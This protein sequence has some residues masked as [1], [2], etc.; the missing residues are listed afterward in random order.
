MSNRIRLRMA[1]DAGVTLIE[2]LIGF[3]IFAILTTL[4]FT[5]VMNGA[6]N[7]K[8]VRQTTDLN[9]EA[10]LVLNRMSRE[11]REASAI[12]AAQNPDASNP[13]GSQRVCGTSPSPCFDPRADVS[14]TFEVDFNRNGAIEPLAA[15]P[16]RITYRYDYANRRLL[17]QTATET[18]PILAGNVS[19]FKLSYRSSDY[20]CDVN[21]NGDVTWQELESASSPP[22]PALA[23]SLVSG[24]SG[25]DS[26]L[27]YVDQIVIDLTVLTP[28]RHQQYRTK[29]DLR[30]RG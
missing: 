18:T 9:E 4:A 22:C 13:D 16:E 28:P 23:G 11:L 21:S 17:L 20:K 1:S 8:A 19:A 30:N 5:T 12:T 2:M 6:S 27:A 3:F 26:E 10:R 25:L 24:S 7:L 29:V 15:D 14:V